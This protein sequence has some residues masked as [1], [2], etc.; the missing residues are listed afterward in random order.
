MRLLL[1]TQILFWVAG[2]SARLPDQTRTVLEAPEN[3]L[4][5][6]AANLWEVMIKL[7]LGRQDFQVDEST[8]TRSTASR[9]RKRWL[10]DSR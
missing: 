9:L 5:F 10:K 3:R 4:Y 1:D 7:G 6:S 2:E 8:K